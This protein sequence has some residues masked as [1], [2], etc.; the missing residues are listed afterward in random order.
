MA[1]S[2]RWLQAALAVLATMALSAPLWLALP[3]PPQARVIDQ[4]WFTAPGGVGRSVAGGTARDMPGGA[5]DEA[6]GGMTG[7]MTGSVTADA[8]GRRVELPH[9]QGRGLVQG[10]YRMAFELAEAPAQS[11]YLFIPTFSYR[12]VVALDGEVVLDT[13]A[14]SLV[15]GVM[16]GASALVP[17]S[18]RHMAAG[19]HAVDI[20][21]EAPGVMR[22][23]LSPLYLGTAQQ[24]APYHRLRVLVFEHTRMMVLACQLLL[25]AATL[26]VWAYRPRESLYGWLFLLL[27]VSTASY[28]GLLADAVPD[29]FAWLPY[30]Y[31]LSMSSVFVLHVIALLVNGTAPP[32]WLRASVVAVPGACLLAMASGIAPVHAL[33]AGVVMP[34]MVASPLI[35]VAI[36]AWGALVKKMREAW[37]LLPPLVFFSLAT[38][39]DGAVVAG[40]LDGPVF[41]SL[42]YRLLLILAIAAILMRRLGLSLTRLDGANAHLKRR[43]A[44]REAELRRLHEQERSEAARRVRSE[45]RRRLTA[46]LHDGLSGHLAS[47]IA[48]AERGRSAGIERSA[49]EALDDLR[50]VIHSLDVGDRELTAA[51]SGLR[52]RLQPQLGRLGVELEWSMARLPE[53][54]GLTPA[55]A[56]HVLRIVQE[57][58]TNA[59]RHGPAS[60]ITVRGSAGPRGEAIITVENDGVPY[61][62]PDAGVEAGT[63]ADARANEGAGAE[64]GAPVAATAS[65][66]A[67][68]STR[69]GG[70]G[71]RNMHRRAVL[72]GGALRIEALAGGTRVTLTL[73]SRLPGSQA[74]IRAAEA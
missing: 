47:I 37:L 45:E 55:H 26:V 71:V 64:A 56:L 41:L 59:L 9:A 20:L 70:A 61:S 51:L 3:V 6:A 13:G 17:L 28:A 69:T 73:P 2:R 43:L 46:D 4:A 34:I 32:G 22:G 67:G 39:H 72:L 38:L 33:M 66:E 36:S 57:A 65:A 58:S 14:D 42:Y 31:A 10:R 54:S 68:A 44:E 19:R 50:L 23:Y 62:D 40:M 11:L 15:P 48:Q 18:A 35:T 21:L 29:I 49:R 8:A 27:A 53:V 16:L 12:A 63:D 24:I 60:R 5:A 25:A 30:A 52:E 74:D 7:D 1:V